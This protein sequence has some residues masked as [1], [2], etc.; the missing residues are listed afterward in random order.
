MA[1]HPHMDYSLT[2]AA[3]VPYDHTASKL[4]GLQELP[5]A[6]DQQL[7]RG[8]DV[9]PTAIQRTPEAHPRKDPKLEKT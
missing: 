6:S 1:Q 7:P 2:E 4:R 8:Q 5:T 9:N 3:A